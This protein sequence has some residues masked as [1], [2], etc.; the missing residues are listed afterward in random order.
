MVGRSLQAEYYREPLQ[1]PFR[2]EIAVEA[3]GLSLAGA[4]RDV[5]A[6]SCT[7]RDSGHCRGD[8]FGPRGADA[9][10]CRLRA[11]RRRPARRRRPRGDASHA[12]RGGGQRHRLHSARAPRRRPGAVPAGRRQHHAG[13]PR[14]PEQAR[15]DRCARG[16]PAGDELGRAPQGSHAR[17]QH[18]V[19]QPVGRQPAE[20]GAGEM[21]ERQGRGADPRPPD[22]R[23]RRRRQGRGLRTG[24]GPSPRKA[25]PS[26]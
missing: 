18:A 15:A 17:H 10:A 26:S 4:Y 11:A 12:G 3:D 22:A 21:A 9:D 13:G 16:E 20:G 8:R 5:V 1:K 2:D 23:A 25:S 19:P 7:G 14:Q 6:S 24:R